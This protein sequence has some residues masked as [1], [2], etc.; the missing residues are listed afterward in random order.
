MDRFEIEG[1]TALR[2]EVEVSGAKNAALPIL[3]ATLLADGE[4]RLEGVPDLKDIQTMLRILEQLGVEAE[5]QPDGALLTEVVDPTPVR[6]PY[7]LVKTMRASICVL[8]P[9][10]G[11]RHGPRSASPAAA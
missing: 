8:G 6:A 4:C 1:G 9:L 5:R 10:L 3:A 7:E 11:R 2:G